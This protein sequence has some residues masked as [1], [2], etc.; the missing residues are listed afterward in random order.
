MIT[1]QRLKNA[2]N[3]TKEAE[4]IV[5]EIVYDEKGNP[6]LRM[7]LLKMGVPFHELEDYE[8]NCIHMILEH[9]SGKFQN[10]YQK[11][12]IPFEKYMW[13]F[14]IQTVLN[15][16]KKKNIYHSRYNSMEQ[17]LEQHESNEPYDWMG[18]VEV[19][20]FALDIENVFMEMTQRQAFICRCLYY[21]D[22][23][24][25]EIINYLNIDKTTYS[26]EIEEIKKVLK[27]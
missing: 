11:A 19:D 18:S 14:M 9:I 20:E 22:W 6:K 5:D 8:M 3:D 13:F 23:Q 12:K 24:A 17:I 16:F 15:D 10:K 4:K 2:S 7:Y 25:F 27:T 1:L 21:S 26:H